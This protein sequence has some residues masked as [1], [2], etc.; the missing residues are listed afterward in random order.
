MSLTRDRDS[1]VPAVEMWSNAPGGWGCGAW[2]E[3]K[4]L[5]IAWS[6][7]PTFVDNSIA[8]KELWQSL[9]V[10]ATV[11]GVIGTLLL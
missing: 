11:G 3:A 7:W 6:E 9:C 8:A 5:Q 10:V 2:W 1:S 4:W